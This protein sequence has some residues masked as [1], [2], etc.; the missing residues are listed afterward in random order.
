MENGFQ[1]GVIH[2]D[3][4]QTKRGKERQNQRNRIT[5]GGKDSGQQDTG[6]DTDG[7]SKF[8]FQFRSS[9]FL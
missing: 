1:F 2:S 4:C 8:C 7:V 6:A 9:P 5:D 3:A